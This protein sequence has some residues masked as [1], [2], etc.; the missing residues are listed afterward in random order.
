MDQLQQAKSGILQQ[1]QALEGQLQQLQTNSLVDDLVTAKLQLA[2]AQEQT[3]TLEGQFNKE[4]DKS[5]RLAAQLTAVESKYAML[6]EQQAAAAAAA[7]R[8]QAAEASSAA[9][10]TTGAAAEQGEGLQIAPSTAVGSAVAVA[11]GP[12]AVGRGGY[13]SS[14]GSMFMRAGS[15]MLG[16]ATASPSNSDSQQ[17]LQEGVRRVS[18]PGS[19]PGTLEHD[20]QRAPRLSIS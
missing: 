12:I 14:W 2:Q 18:E 3:I 8:Q 10:P 5:R 19:V 4:K 9:A 20:A 1:L 7:A 17:Q 11:S 6:Y 16:S 15:Y 13:S